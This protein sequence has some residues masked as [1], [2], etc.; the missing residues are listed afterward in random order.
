MAFQGARKFIT[1]T[2]NNVIGQAICDAEDFVISGG[3]N[4]NSVFG[5]LTN[6]VEVI[7]RP[8]LVPFGSGWE[9]QLFPDATNGQVIYTVY[10][11]CFDNPSPH[12]DLKILFFTYF[13]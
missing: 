4:I 10:A 9:V 13:N 3:F 1:N 6:I 12:R 5:G 2:T 11:I 8:I 7:N